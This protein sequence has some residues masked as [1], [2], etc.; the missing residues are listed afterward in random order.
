MSFFT[1]TFDASTMDKM[2]Y[3]I[4]VLAIAVTISVIVLVADSVFAFLPANPFGAVRAGK[5]FWTSS[6]PDSENLIVPAKMS[7]SVTP[8][9]YTVTVQLMVGDSRTPSIGRYRHIL[10]RGSNPCGLTSS[11]AGPS[12]HAGIQVGDIPATAEASYKGIG[13]PAVM[14]PGLFLDKQ[15]NDLHVFVHTK[16][17][18][19]TLWLESVTVA[20]VPLGTPITV[21]VVCNGRTLEVYLNCRLYSTLLLKGTPYLPSANN[22]WFGRYGAFPMS[23]L[24]KDLHIWDAPLNSS[25]YMTTC[26]SVTFNKKELPATCSA[27]Q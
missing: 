6:P 25:D 4:Y 22:Q 10:H 14:N 24:V 13:L 12:G 15:R 2:K 11:V 9:N 16:S 1:N 21:G 8:D 5:K 27:Q 19:G 26:R 18:T 23:G 20:D 7:P 3:V 17:N